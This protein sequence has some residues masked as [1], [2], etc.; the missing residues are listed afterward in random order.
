MHYSTI[1][2]NS[3][4][5]IFVSLDIMQNL[6]YVD[7]IVNSLKLPITNYSKNILLIKI[8]QQKICTHLL[9]NNCLL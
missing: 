6:F 3:D 7:I 9:I 8:K 5:L 4:S 2:N 1:S